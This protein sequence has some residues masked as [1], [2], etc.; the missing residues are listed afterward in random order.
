MH[1]NYRAGSVFHRMSVV[2]LPFHRLRT[3]KVIGKTRAG[4]ITESGHLRHDPYLRSPEPAYTV[5]TVQDKVVSLGM[6]T[7]AAKR[8][9]RPNRLPAGVRHP[10]RQEYTMIVIYTQDQTI[11]RK[12]A[13]AARKDLVSLYGKKLGTEAYETVRDER[14]GSAYRKY[15]GPLVK[16]VSAEDAEKIKE[17]ETRIGAI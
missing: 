11:I 16:T 4:C 10:G 2:T 8:R 5:A 12:N 15:G 1:I 3:S 7:T 6:G 14:I 17:K 13:D 9:C